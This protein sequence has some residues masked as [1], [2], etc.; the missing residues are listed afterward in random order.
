MD[1]RRY[2][3]I[4][5]SIVLISACGKKPGLEGQAAAPS[6]G[7][8]MVEGPN[9]SNFKACYKDMDGLA[10]FQGD[11]VLGSVEQ[12]QM[13]TAV[14][15]DAATSLSSHEKDRFWPSSLI[16]YTVEGGLSLSAIIT[17]Q[18]DLTVRAGIIFVPRSI[19]TDYI[20]YVP[21]SDPAICGLS[22]IG[23][24]GG[25]QE[26]KIGI[27][28]QNDRTIQHETMHAL[29]FWHE[30][31][32]PDRDDHIRIRWENVKDRFLSDFDKMP[33]LAE[34][35]GA[36]DF[37]SV[38]HYRRNAFS[39]NGDDTI[40]AD[41]EAHNAQIGTGTKASDGDILG[42]KAIYG[43]ETEVTFNA[44][45]T[46]ATIKFKTPVY[47]S[48]RVRY[49]RTRANLDQSVLESPLKLS[50][51]VKLTGL[52]PKTRYF[53]KVVTGYDLSAQPA[54]G[55]TRS[56]ITDRT[57]PQILDP[58]FTAD[59]SE[60]EFR[61]STD[62]DTI[63]SV[64]YYQLP[65]KSDK[66][67]ARDS[68]FGNVHYM[69]FSVGAGNWKFVPT[70]IDE[71]G[72]ETIGAVH[73][74]SNDG[75][76]PI[77]SN[78]NVTNR[79]AT[80]ATI[81][82]TTNEAAST[83]VDYGTSSGNL[84]T[85]R[86]GAAAALSHSVALTGLSSNQTYYYRV[87]SVDL[88]GRSTSSAI[89]TLSTDFS[90][91]V[92]SGVGSSNVSGTGARISWT[93]NE[94]SDSKVIWGTN[95]ASFPNTQWLAGD[96][97]S[98]VVDI[99]GLNPTTFYCY[100]VVSKDPQGNESTSAAATFTTTAAPPPVL[101]AALVSVASSGVTITWNTDISSSSVVIYGTSS[102]SYPSTASSAGNT[103][104]H[105]VTIA[106]G[107]L[108]QGQTYY[109][110][111]RSASPSGA[112]ATG[113]EQSFIFQD[114]VTVSVALNGYGQYWYLP[115]YVTAT[116]NKANSG[117]T[118]MTLKFIWRSGNQEFDSIPMT[119][120][121]AANN[122]T[123]EIPFGYSYNYIYPGSAYLRVVSSLGGKA[124]WKNY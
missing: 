83:I 77:I 28:C 5:F 106:A 22:H 30:Q 91:P 96:V 64:T 12:L 114:T 104:A 43:S 70:V 39:M 3:L 119:Y 40:Q 85:R 15:S 63:A 103:T 99:S 82:W 42:L 76:A 36:Y 86:T 2:I 100:K 109:F 108:V 48:S 75:T 53:F 52:T 117:S 19:Q 21:T 113:P 122:Y 61:L 80:T 56:F 24:Q 46:E 81:N 35:L 54:Y 26:V 31:S 50:H 7:C 66:R 9:F 14:D 102:G 120:N 44:A 65:D 20:A 124:E 116:S 51:E 88:G 59:G 74:F 79:T 23:R 78:I 34:G 89:L 17:A 25:R 18:T 11:I 57:A 37:A 73:H 38:M 68:A 6:D 32:R 115:R 98:H 107:S 45:E 87:T 58:R 10:V 110:K 112:T 90:A 72:N 1:F 67:V 69:K 47:I 121:A 84:S 4:A 105:S 60:I 13:R 41:T 111:V 95:C 123:A 101:T 55:I 27:N 16:P 29:G 93:T 118:T 92:I 94:V 8:A 71:A 49:G 62:E 33:V 97:T